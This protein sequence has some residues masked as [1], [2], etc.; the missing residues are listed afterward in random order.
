MMRRLLAICLMGLLALP[1]AAQQ[2][3]NG[4]PELLTTLEDG[5]LQI[6][7]D[8]DRLTSRAEEVIA[9]GT[10]SPAA[11][12]ILRRDLLEWRGAF[13]RAAEADR[14]RIDVVQAQITALG[15]EPVEG[16]TEPADVAA[17]RMQLTDRLETVMAPSLQARAAFTQADSLIAETDRLIEA[18]RAQEILRKGPI[19]INPVNWPTAFGAIAAWMKGLSTDL[20]KP[21]ATPTARAVWQARGVELGIL[22]F[23]AILLLWRSGV[24]LG[25]FRDQI[26]VNEASRA[27]V[28]VTLLFISLVRLILPVLGLVVL[29]RILQL[30]GASGVRIDAAQTMVPVMGLIVL[31]AR[32]LALQALPKRETA[33]AFLPV[34]PERRPEAR[35]HAVTLGILLACAFAVETITPSSANPEVS[36]AIS[37]FVL[38]VIAGVNLLRLGQLFLSEGN[39]SRTDDGDGLWG[40]VLRL[41]GRALIAVGVFAPLLATA[42]YVNLGGAILWPTVMSLAVIMLIGILQG[43][44]FDIYAALTRRADAGRDALTPTLVGFALALASLPVLALIWGVRPATLIEWWSTFM[45]GFS[46]GGTEISP[47]NFLTFALVF[48]IGYT[49]VRLLKGV[50]R[51]NILPKTSM[52]TGG[53]N[54]VLSGTGYVGI[55]LSALIAITAAGIDLSGL[56]IVA[57]A[58]SVGIGFGLQTIVQNFVSGI[59]LL[60]ERPIK[61]GD[62]VNVGGVEGFVRQISVRST[63]IETFDRQDVIVPNAD[64]IS[65]V[66]TNYTLANSAGRVVL[67]VGVAYGTDTRRVEAILQ[68]VAEIHPMVV[69]EPPPLVTFDGFGADSLNFTIR[70]VIRDILFKPRVASEIY[71]LIAER[72]VAEKLEIP[73]AQRDLWLRNPETL[74]PVASPTSEA[75]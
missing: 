9:S 20:W 57:G 48:V 12:E 32:W 24:W 74:R 37:H 45:R 47:S 35:L 70:V 73:F 34:A 54:A 21:F 64:L 49:A 17:K 7:P 30:M 60:V 8:W 56:A 63:R 33:Q 29:V 42:G 10:A 27:G 28:R 26:A 71:H 39:L 68:E 13:E 51:T 53:T 3:N 6:P 44:V 59:I 52:D 36:R 66:V 43:F 4:P 18:D 31:S 19:P 25:N 40:Q 1:V 14:A 22:T 65:G 50:L 23:A 58:L 41:L 5:R 38:L 75:T 72:F 11:L 46:L 67:H 15:P 55:T 61:L 16:A 2:A 69:L 62:W